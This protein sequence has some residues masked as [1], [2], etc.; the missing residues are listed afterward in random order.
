MILRTFIGLADYIAM[1]RVHQAGAVT[2]TRYLEVGRSI[3]WAQHR[4]NELRSL[5]MQECGALARI[6]MKGKRQ[7]MISEEITFWRWRDERFGN[8][9]ALTLRHYQFIRGFVHG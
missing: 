7:A 3:S 9:G 1:C 5:V 2:M 8:P 4:R 6:A